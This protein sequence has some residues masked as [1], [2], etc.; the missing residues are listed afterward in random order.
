MRS[1]TKNQQNSEDWLP[2]P[3]EWPDARMAG[4]RPLVNRDYLPFVAGPAANACDTT[5]S[6]TLGARIGISPSAR[7]L[8]T[9]VTRPRWA[10][11]HTAPLPVWCIVKACA[12]CRLR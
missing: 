12:A 2:Q 8:S 1:A 10:V 11:V 6:L 3:D 7:V 5:R 9:C 4:G